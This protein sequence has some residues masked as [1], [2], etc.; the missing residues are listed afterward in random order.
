M[1]LR[2][3]VLNTTEENLDLLMSSR[4]CGGG[5]VVTFL[6]LSRTWGCSRGRLSILLN[7]VLLCRV[8]L[9]LLCTAVLGV[10]RLGA[11]VWG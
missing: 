1:L 3:D 7:T 9:V 11:G 10:A 2:V 8:L 4:T 5:G 6:K